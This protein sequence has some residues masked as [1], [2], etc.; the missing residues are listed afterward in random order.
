MA[1]K[2]VTRQS[3]VFEAWGPEKAVDG[4]PGNPGWKPKQFR[5]VCSHTKS[6]EPE[7]WWTVRFSRAVNINS[8]VIYNRRRD[9]PV[10]IDHGESG[11]GGLNVTV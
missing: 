9:Q 7:G 1:L 8:F 3:S 5:R 2:Q 4:N 11:L 10:D 6:S